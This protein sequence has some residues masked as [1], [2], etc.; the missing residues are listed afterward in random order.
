VE[1]RQTSPV[2]VSGYPDLTSSKETTASPDELISPFK[3]FLLNKN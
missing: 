1:I 2:I 3:H